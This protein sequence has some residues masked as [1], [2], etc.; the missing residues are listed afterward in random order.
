VKWRNGT[1]HASSVYFDKGGRCDLSHELMDR[2][3]RSV[4]AL[5]KAVIRELEARIE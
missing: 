4:E 3:F 2:G 5:T 1:F